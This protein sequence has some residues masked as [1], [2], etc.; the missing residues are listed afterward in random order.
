MASRAIFQSADDFA[1]ID[2]IAFGIKRDGGSLVIDYLF[3]P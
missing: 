2:T 3:D 1:V